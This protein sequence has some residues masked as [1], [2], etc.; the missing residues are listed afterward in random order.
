RIEQE[1]NAGRV[2]GSLATEVDLYCDGELREH[3]AS[4]SDE[5]R[6]VL[7]SS[8]ARVH[9]LAS[10]AAEG[11]TPS[12][13]DGLSLK[14]STTAHSKCERCWHHRESVGQTEKYPDLCD[15]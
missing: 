11:A 6:F 13:L 7:L 3:L 8:Y 12:E 4:L 14:V 10:A 15:R 5:L 2:K 1:R 9:G